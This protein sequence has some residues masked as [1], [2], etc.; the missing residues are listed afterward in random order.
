[1]RTII[2]TKPDTIQ[3]QFIAIRDALTEAGI[4]DP[5]IEAE[6]LIRHV[7]GLNR[8]QYFSTLTGPIAPG[9]IEVLN[10]LVASRLTGEPLAYITG[11]REFY[12]LEIAVNRDV[13][14]PRQETELLV[15]LALEYIGTRSGDGS[16][17]VT[18]VA[19]VC[20]GSGAIGVA[21]AVNAKNIRIHAIDISGPALEV[22]ERNVRAFNVGK[23]VSVVESDLMAD[24]PGPYDLILCNPPYIPTEMLGGLAIEVRNEPAIALDGGPDGLRF[25]RRLLA[26]SSAA[27]RCPG[28]LLVELMPEQIEKAI[29][30]A[31]KTFPCA[32]VGY[33]ADLAG[34][35]RALTVY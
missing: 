8:S 30:L 9:D 14:I 16:Q 18:T 32:K 17:P 1:M 11:T 25:F 35:P 26:Q 10:R 12:G 27:L 5:H 2:P 28:A 6:V 4:D 7:L 34:N 29:V 13:L 23:N 24:S 31:E 15:D 33:S 22:A 20:T 3:T 19:D 21:I